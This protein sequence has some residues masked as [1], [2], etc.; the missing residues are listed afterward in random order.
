MK[1]F[2]TL[3]VFIM[4]LW[5]PLNSAFTTATLPDTTPESIKSSDLKGFKLY[6]PAVQSLINQALALTEKKLTYTYGSAD[7]KNGGMDCSGTIY[8]LLNFANQKDMPRATDQIYEWVLKYGKFYSVNATTFEAQDFNNLQ[9]GDLLFWTGTWEVK[10]KS[11]LSHVMLY[12]GTDQ[13]GNRLMF[14]SSNGRSYRGK[15]IW[16]VSIFDFKL[17][18]PDSKARFIGYSCIPAINC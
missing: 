11:P 8:Y 3:V 13:S 18:A 17:P 6:K 1:Y 10:R 7:P 9:P 2:N 5:L 15:Q 16:G 4:L 14:G 12:L